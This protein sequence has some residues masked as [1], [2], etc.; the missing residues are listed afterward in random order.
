MF[1]P[2][3]KRSVANVLQEIRQDK[4]Q[5]F[6]YMNFE[7]DN[8]T[9][10][11][12]RAKEIL[13]GIIA[14]HLQFDETFFFGRTDLAKDEELLDLLKEAH[15]TRVLMGIESL[16]QKALDRIHK[17]QSVQDIKDAARRAGSTASGSSPRSS[18]ASTTTACGH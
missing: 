6:R 2:Y 12:E 13:R 11:K 10:D 3:R 7:D 14:G 8:F 1:A 15:L 9:A 17:G 16:N 5:G 4:E 18:W